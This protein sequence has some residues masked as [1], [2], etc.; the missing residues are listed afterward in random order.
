LALGQAILLI[1][2]PIPLGLVALPMSVLEISVVDVGPEIQLVDL[3]IA[4][5][6]T[7]R[8]V[9]VAGLSLEGRVI[10][11]QALDLCSSNVEMCV[12]S[13]KL[14]RMGES[15]EYLECGSQIGRRRGEDVLAIALR[16]EVVI[17]VPWS[18][19]SGLRCRDPGVATFCSM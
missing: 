4:G 8:V 17:E 18:W 12:S 6:M 13:F 2:L 10:F 3:V 5:A 16:D 11:P 14:G 19:W 9:R 7:H 1:V 15:I